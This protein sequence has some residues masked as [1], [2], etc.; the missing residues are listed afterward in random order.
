MTNEPSRLDAWGEQK[1]SELEC[2]SRSSFMAHCSEQTK[3]WSV[4]TFFL[5]VEGVGG[6]YVTVQ[7]QRWV[8]RTE[9][10]HISAVSIF[11]FRSSE[12]FWAFFASKTSLLVLSLRRECH[13]CLSCSVVSTE[14]G[15]ELRAFRGVQH[16]PADGEH[17][18]DT[19][20]ASEEEK[21]ALRR[22]TACSCPRLQRCSSVLHA[23][24]LY[25]TVLIRSGEYLS[26]GGL[27]TSS[28]ALLSLLIRRAL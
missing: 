24:L 28:R 21:C 3:K 11:F 27:E 7:P 5:L 2:R 12:D 18:S 16:R 6:L 20:E 22:E 9:W 25:C 8:C 15:G 19:G 13:F 17:R 1:R 14:W 10:F 26:P 4:E 23:R